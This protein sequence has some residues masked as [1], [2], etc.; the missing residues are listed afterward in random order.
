VSCVLSCVVCFLVLSFA[1]CC[2]LPSFVLIFILALAHFHPV[3]KSRKPNTL[4]NAPVTLAPYFWCGSLLCC[5]YCCL[6]CVVVFFRGLS[7]ILCCLFSY[8]FFC[9]VLL[10]PFGC[11]IFIL[12]CPICIQLARHGNRTHWQAR[13]YSTLPISGIAF[14]CVLPCLVFCLVLCSALSCVLPCLVFCL[15][16]CSALS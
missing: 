8:F 1:L 6:P 16:L 5:L 14:S 7:S 11:H 9:L 12:P 15:V 2:Y 13:L 10:F 4:A 3:A